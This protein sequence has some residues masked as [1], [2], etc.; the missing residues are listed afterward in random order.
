MNNGKVR[1]YEL[2]K[3]LNLDNKELLAICDQLNIAVKSHSS[4]ITESEAERIRSQAE[5]LAATHQM[6]KKEH[7]GAFSHKPNTTQ[8]PSHHR[9]AASQKQELLEIRKPQPPKNKSGNAFE[10]SAATNTEIA[11]SEV[12]P[13]S[14]P[15]PFAT[16]VSSMKPTAP[17]RPIS[18]NQ[19]EAMPETAVTNADKT[20]KPNNHQPTE[21]MAEEKPE[22]TSPAPSKLK[23]ERPQKPQ[24]VS[25]PTRPAADKSELTPQAHQ[26]EKPILKR[27]R[28]QTREPVKGKGKPQ[29]ATNAEAKDT[30]Q[31]PPRPARP[32]AG[33][34]SSEQKGN[35]GASVIGESPRPKP[36]TR[37][38][39]APAAVGP[40]KPGLAPVKSQVGQ[41]EETT[42][43]EET[44]EIVELKRPTPPRQPKIGKKWQEEEIDEAKEANKAKTGVKG[45]RVKPIVDEEDFEED[46]LDDEDAELAAAAV[47]ISNAIVRPPKPKTGKPAQT[48]AVAAA[49]KPTKKPATA[50]VRD[51]QRRPQEQKRDRPETLVVTGT[52]T[53]QELA[54]ALVVADTEI[55]K[56][57]FLKGMAVSI[58]Q[59]LDIPTITLIANELGTEVETQEPEAEARKVTEMI[60]VA[61]LENLHRRPPVVTIMGH[62]DHGKTTLLDSIRNTKVASGEAGGITQHIGA[63]H[64]DVEHGG[65]VQQVVFL[66]TPGHEAFTAM[67]ARGARV[68]DIAILVVAADDGVRP[69]TIEAISHAKAA[70]VPIV[71][72]INKIDKEGA[73]PDRVKQELTNYGLTSEEWG[74]DTIMVPV[75][76]IKGENLDTL[77]EMILL[78][79]EVEELSANPDRSAKGT[80]IE[81]H[82]DKAK[83]AVATLLVQNG[84][85]RVGD[86]LVAGSV[87]GKVRAMIDDR[88]RKVEA[89]TPSFAVEVLGLSDVPAA[90]D[91]FEVFHIEK[92]A[93]S[94]ASDRAEKQ[95]QS[96]LMQGRVTLAA[97]SAQ[98]QEG[99]L[100]ELNLILKGDVQGSVEA[101]VGSLR[102]IPQNEVQIR[103]LLASAGEITQ[104]D[105]DLAAASGAVIIGFNTTYASGARQAADEAGV[106][107]RE[108]NIIYKLLED[109]QGALEGLL[110]PELVEEPLGQAEV[111]AVFPVG[112]GAVAGCYVQSGKLLRN[113]KLRVRRGSKVVY[114]GILDS[115]KRMKEDTREVNPGFECGVGVDKY[116]DWAEGD[117][118]EAYQMVTK[119]RTLSAAAR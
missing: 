58:T 19:S 67:R 68:T 13:L 106:D 70:E 25:P 38:I 44:P 11:S 61:D 51:Q 111:R 104:T 40:Q 16:P 3:E 116:S 78:V 1:I 64:V 28:D 23:P 80:V 35:R 100:K 88:G 48:S 45:K 77:L 115:L 102:Q 36:P 72:A 17:I 117:I 93:R 81:A 94:L 114:E 97:I 108:Y 71:V 14:P 42:D 85:L 107:V 20:P 30:T 60:D 118:I 112:R 18:R 47:A 34:A 99:E 84:T 43:E 101:I 65:K 59:S 31:Q 76:A 66:D 63:Y 7:H 12:N 50:A 75:S 27:D 46:F 6:P 29:P 89:A 39:P 90:G 87:F 62:V 113:C 52:M 4:T 37:P 15:R 8:I 21:K 103:L 74:G 9:P 26:A 73:Q 105:I 5:K 2:S 95:R 91:E 83:G 96:R 92:E 54:D 110:E 86:I 57:L 10:A 109:I 119:R 55:V 56:I 98:A 82:L 32:V 49:P 69:Q 41:E 33:R 53:V 79:A 22:L 24:L